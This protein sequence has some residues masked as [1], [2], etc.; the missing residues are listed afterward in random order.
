MTESVF[1]TSCSLVNCHWGSDPLPDAIQA[2][3]A[4]RKHISEHTHGSLVEYICA[5]PSSIARYDRAE[6]A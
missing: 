1:V 3:E 6:S 2:H 5:L 4:L